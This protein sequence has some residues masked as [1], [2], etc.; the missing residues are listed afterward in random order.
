MTILSD[1][2]KKDQRDLAAIVALR[3]DMQIPPENKYYLLCPT[4]VEFHWPSSFEVA[5]G[6]GKRILPFFRRRP[7]IVSLRVTGR[8]SAALHHASDL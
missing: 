3:D 4:G 2:E 8:G 5:D 7:Y 1:A 6:L